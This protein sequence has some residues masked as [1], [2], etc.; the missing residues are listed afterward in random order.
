MPVA[1]DSGRSPDRGRSA[2]LERGGGEDTGVEG[3]DEYGA[4]LSVGYICQQA[5]SMHMND[6]NNRTS[7]MR[8]ELLTEAKALPRVSPVWEPALDPRGLCTAG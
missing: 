8:R 6:M 1:E 7:R 5:Q 3:L 2:T 4:L